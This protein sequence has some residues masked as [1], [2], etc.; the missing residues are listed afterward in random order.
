VQHQDLT[1]YLIVLSAAIRPH[2]A[3]TTAATIWLYS[4]TLTVEFSNCSLAQYTVQCEP[5][6]QHIAEIPHAQRFETAFPLLQLD[7]FP[8]AETGHA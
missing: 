8:T 4:E 7:Q 6:K 2:G 3:P 1:A 5:D